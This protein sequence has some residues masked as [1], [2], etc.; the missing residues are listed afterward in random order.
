MHL[1]FDTETSGLPTAQ[2]AEHPEQPRVMQVGAQLLDNDFVVRGELNLLLKW[3]DRYD[4]HPLAFKAHGIS[5]EMTQ[6]LGVCPAQAADLFAI[7]VERAKHFAAF[8]AKFDFQLTT[9]WAAQTRRPKPFFQTQPFC[10]M[11]ALTPIMKLPG[12]WANSFK[13]PNLQE[14]HVFCTGRQFDGA[15]DAMADVR[16][17]GEVYKWLKRREAEQKELL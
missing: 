10:P 5:W 16:A 8:N 9:I 13:R 17:L 1:I 2:A 3:P 11:L 6:D 15:H 7:F 4:V 12:K 14:A